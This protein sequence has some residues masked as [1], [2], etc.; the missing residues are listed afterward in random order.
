MRR[1]IA[2]RLD[3]H[4]GGRFFRL[5][6]ICPVGGGML[7]PIRRGAGFG[8]SIEVAASVQNCAAHLHIDTN[9]SD[10]KEAVI[11]PRV[12]MVG[13][14]AKDPPFVAMKNYSINSDRSSV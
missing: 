8:L 14:F 6:H 13:M 7:H 12:S 3:E 4:D 10:L 9:V 11:G 5:F 1:A 2:D